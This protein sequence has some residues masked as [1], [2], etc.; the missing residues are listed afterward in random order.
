MS[1]ARILVIEDEQRPAE[2]LQIPLYESG[3]RADIANEDYVGKRL[4]EQAAF[5]L[6]VLDIN[7]PL[8][9]GTELNSEIRKINS[10]TTPIIMLTALE[11][12]EN[13]LIGF[14]S[15][16][17]NY[18]IKYFD[19]KELLVSLNVFLK[20]LHI[21]IFFDRKLKIADFEKDLDSKIATCV[22][23]KNDLTSKEFSLMETLLKNK[24]KVL[25]ME[26]IIENEWNF[27]FV[28]RA[29]IINVYMNYLRKKVDKD[30][31]PALIH[32][33]YGFGFYCS[34]DEL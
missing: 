33:K 20:R 25:S 16:A 23:K 22:G 1:N 17:D 9:N 12:P 7:L 24:K 30:F 8:I 21:A 13:N 5:D 3:F 27:D 18:V 29:N 4:I 31:E 28:T 15:V 14:E 2:F 6:V 32:T 26:Y 19:F 34:E 10:S 11:T